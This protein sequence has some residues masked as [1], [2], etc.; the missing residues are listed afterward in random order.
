MQLQYADEK[1]KQAVLRICRDVDEAGGIA[2]AVGGCVRDTALG[3][4]AKDIDIEVLHV[5]PPDLLALLQR[6]FHIN[7]VGQAFGVIKIG[8]LPIDVAIP[9]RESKAGLGH[10]GFNIMSDPELP[11]KEAAARRDFT[12]NAIAL[13]PLNGQVIDPF[14]GID[15]I[16]RRI[17]RHTTEKFAEDPLRVLRAMQFAARFEMTVA[18]ETI[19]LCSRIEPE[20]L[21]CERI[22]EEWRKLL[23]LGKHPSRGLTFLRDCNWIRYYPELQAL[24]DCPQDPKWHP[25]GDVWNHTLQCLDAFAAE[26]INVPEED[27][28]VG[29][30]VLC[31]DFGKPA[32]TRTDDTGK[33]I[34]YGHEKAGI[35][36]ALSFL[37]RMTNQ[38]RMIDDIITLITHHMQPL[39]LQNNH[40]GNNAIRRLA[41]KVK[42]IDR[43]IRVDRADRLGRGQETIEPLN[44]H[45]LLQRAQKLG[46]DAQPPAP[47]IQGRHLQQYRLTPG[48][49]FGAILNACYEAQ[50]EGAFTDEASGTLYLEHYLEALRKKSK[51]K[52]D[53]HDP[54]G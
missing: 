18:P 28:I 26:R 8:N 53:L 7:L 38:A 17:L 27:L 41:R 44:E 30:A 11:H 16:Q 32:V 25:E 39:Q 33:I 4:P 49:Q 35:K 13:N 23:L 48:P 31:H 21:P 54:T 10:R 5:Q 15:D 24:I 37:R 20:G 36:P 14:H 34:A 29:F 50:L 22:F 43:L 12:I 6:D 9:R 1:L 46:I 51:K 19:E 52:V 45:W 42:R 3:L 40:A 2:Y 47:I